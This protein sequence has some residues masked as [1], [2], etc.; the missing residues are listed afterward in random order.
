LKRLF[1]ELRGREKKT[2]Q[3]IGSRDLQRD[4]GGVFF[5]LKGD[6]PARRKKL[7]GPRG[8]Q[9][10]RWAQGKKTVAVPIPEKREGQS[11]PQTS[12]T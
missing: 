10:L 7:K 8:R 2:V 11:S 3:Y 9:Y 4:R 12:K 5:N 6:P 1:F